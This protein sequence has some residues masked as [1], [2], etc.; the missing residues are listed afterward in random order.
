MR[1]IF[2]ALVVS[3]IGI[4]SFSGNV[5]AEGAAMKISPVA[6][7]FNIKASDVQN[8]TFSIE[9][10]GSEEYSFRLYTAPYNVTDD[11]YSNEFTTETNY[12]QITRWITFQDDSGSFVTNPIYS[13]APGE[14]KTIVYR[15][16]VPDDIP[17]GGQY[18]TIMAETIPNSSTSEA[19]T[20]SID[21]VTR[22]GLI[23][24]G[25][26]SGSTDNIAEIVDYK[27]TG[28]FTRSEVEASAVVKNT[29]NTDFSAT[30]TLT[31]KSIFGKTKVGNFKRP[32]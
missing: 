5:F 13:V 27:L 16:T 30:Y 8:Y 4:F 3:L 10:S 19:N 14:K 2:T 31:A 17:E 23:L 24:I 18:A 7:S 32:F 28:F 21:T 29:G 12:S 9:N 20:M 25:H 26:G 6:N 11:D 22:V 1:K 15:I